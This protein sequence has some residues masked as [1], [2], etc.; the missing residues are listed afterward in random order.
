MKFPPEPRRRDLVTRPDFDGEREFV[1]AREIAESLLAGASPLEIYRR[2]LARV[3]PLLGAD[4]ASV[5]LRD[6]EDPDLLRLV[7]AQSWPQS[8]AR[9]LAEL[10]VREGRGPTGQA[11]SRGEPVEVPDVFA[12]DSLDAWGEPARELGFVCMTAHPL[13]A[14]ER[15]LGAV[16]FYYRE[17]HRFDDRDRALVAVVAHQLARAAGGAGRAS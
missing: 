7:C 2:A 5:F 13:M 17:R 9:F 12:G 10:R 16:S 11:V 8:S 14:H 15:V 1:V 4:F 3:T 6:E